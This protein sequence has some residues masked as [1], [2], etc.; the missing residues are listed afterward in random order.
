MAK[1]LIIDAP[2]H[3]MPEDTIATRIPSSGPARPWCGNP[4]GSPSE[5]KACN[6]S[7]RPR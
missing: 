2:H 7:A 4:T 3:W 5:G 6:S 1:T